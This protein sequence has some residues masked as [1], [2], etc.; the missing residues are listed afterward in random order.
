M[1]ALKTFLAS[2]EPRSIDTP[3]NVQQ[4]EQV[5]KECWSNIK[6]SSA[7]G[8][9]R[10]KLS[11][12]LKEVTWQPPILRFTIERHG[13]TVQGSSRAKLHEWQVNV[14]ESQASCETR[15]HRQLKAMSK[16]IDTG[17]LAAEVFGRIVE[18]AVDQ[19]LKWYPDGRVHVLIGKIIPT[20]SAAKQAVPKRRKRFTNALRELLIDAGWKE[21][22]RDHTYS[23]PVE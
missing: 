16:R 22:V 21:G 20:H 18:H 5:L 12:R 9:T 3:S 19:R 23:P 13:G 8:M 15:R 14:D 1:Q 7:H 4:L 17:K 11:G 6:G 10:K 2:I